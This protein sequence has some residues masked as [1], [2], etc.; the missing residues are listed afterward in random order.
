MLNGKEI[1]ARGIVT[2]KIEEENIQQ[3]GVD[4]NVIEISQI[5]GGG[6]I[7]VKGK[8]RLG[9]SER[10]KRVSGKELELDNMCWMLDPGA[11]SVDFAQGCDIP[12]DFVL[13]IRQRSSLLRN[14]SILHSSVFDPGFSTDKIGTVLIV[15]APILIEYGARIAQAYVHPCTEV[16]VED[17]YEGQ[18]Q[19][20]K[21]RTDDGKD[22]SNV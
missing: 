3:V 22:S 19:N 14:G 18:F 7:P 16:Q 8:T 1:V 2:G 12:A 21:Q 11:Y 6:I 13:L 5:F 10:V 17:L 9:G 15:H 4:L 20:D